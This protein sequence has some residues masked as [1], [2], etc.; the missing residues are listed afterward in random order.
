MSYFDFKKFLQ[1]YSY[2]IQ[3]MKKINIMSA[4]FFRGN[5]I[6]DLDLVF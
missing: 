5:T 4:F 2:I 1:N 3:L 6:N